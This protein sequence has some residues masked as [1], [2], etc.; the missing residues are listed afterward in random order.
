MRFCM[1]IRPYS[2]AEMEKME[3]TILD[4][5]VLAGFLNGRESNS[6]D[7]A[8]G[9]DEEDSARKLMNELTQKDGNG[10][11]ADCGEKSELR[12]LQHPPPPPPLLF[13][14]VCVRLPSCSSLMQDQS[15]HR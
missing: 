8:F 3:G 13:L 15:G 5:P 11:C 1:S 12:A 2:S 14:N 7:S 6:S 4:D 10:I 9:D